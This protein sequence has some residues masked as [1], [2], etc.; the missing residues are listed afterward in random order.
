MMLTCT[1]F[2][3]TDAVLPGWVSLVFIPSI[4]RILLM[5]DPHMLVAIG[6]GQY[7]GRSYGCINAIS[8]DNAGVRNFFYGLEAIPVHEQEF[9]ILTELLHCPVHGKDGSIQNID[10]VDFLHICNTNCI[11]QGL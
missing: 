3:D 6:F 2:Q 11:K 9:R 10:L 7:G 4:R 1:R 5:Q 8:P